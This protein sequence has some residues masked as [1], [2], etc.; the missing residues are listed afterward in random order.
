MHNLVDLCHQ[1]T[2]SV[3]MCVTPQFSLSSAQ[4]HL[5]PGLAQQTDSTNMKNVSSLFVHQ[6]PATK[7]NSCAREDIRLETGGHIVQPVII[8]SFK[9]VNSSVI[10]DK[11]FINIISQKSSLRN[12]VITQT[13]I[14]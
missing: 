1:T 6:K 2:P 3:C 13:H 14:L 12:H 4:P 11:L 9:Y 5:S 8:S 7:E 10:L